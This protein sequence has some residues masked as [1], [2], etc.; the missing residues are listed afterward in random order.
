MKNIRVTKYESSGQ[1]YD[2]KEKVMK[3]TVTLRYYST[4]SLRELTLRQEQEWKYFPDL[5][6]WYLISD[7]LTFP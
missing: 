6:H 2:P 4:D 1:K 7:P 5:K 3:Q